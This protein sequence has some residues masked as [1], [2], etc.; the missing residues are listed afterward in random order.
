[1]RKKGK[2]LTREEAGAERDLMQVHRRF[3]AGYTIVEVRAGWFG[4]G[5]VARDLCENPES[6]AIDSVVLGHGEKVVGAIPAAPGTILIEARGAWPGA[7]LLA[8]GHSFPGTPEMTDNEA[9]D[10][11]IKL[12]GELGY[13]KEP[14]VDD[15]GQCDAG[16]WDAGETGDGGGAGSPLKPFVP[17][18]M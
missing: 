2:E 6:G 17:F 3:V 8:I 7:P 1:M 16:G 5:T 15:D 18:G 13:L 14:C 4:H 9:K 11:Y 10:V 12:L